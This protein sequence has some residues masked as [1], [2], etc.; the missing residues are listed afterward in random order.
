MHSPCSSRRSFVKACAALAALS[1]AS[2]GRVV[3]PAFA[4]EE[5]PKAKLVGRDG[6]PVKASALVPHE[7]YLFL[8]PYIS[9]A[10]LLLRLGEATSR[11]I[12]RSGEDAAPYKWPGGCGKN[13][14][15]VAY[16]AICAHAL[17][18]DGKQ[19]SFLTYSKGKNQISGHERVI[20][21]CAHGS[22]YDPASGAKVVSGPAPFP[23]ASVKLHHDAATDELTAVGFI[24]S[25]LFDRFFASQKE[26]LIAEFGRGGYKELVGGQTAVLPMKEFTKDI[27]QC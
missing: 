2:T 11:D 7:N 10:C 22:I 24:G 26:D 4:L 18:W 8:Y 25:E 13:R 17:T 14:D 23:L 9:T 21:C 19:T 12:E 3:T 5:A 20:T 15:V 16:S 6:K 27:V 1:A